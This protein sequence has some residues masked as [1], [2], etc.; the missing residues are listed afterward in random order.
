MDEAK[1]LKHD[2]KLEA[3]D[4]DSEHRRVITQ[5]LKFA[6]NSRARGLKHALAKCRGPTFFV[7]DKQDKIDIQ[8]QWND[9]NT[10]YAECLS[11]SAIQ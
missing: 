10:A 7:Q 8:R 2:I 4:L 1:Q 11:K 9:M 6:D 5:A 3:V